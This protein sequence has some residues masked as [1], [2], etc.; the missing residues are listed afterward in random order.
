MRA[1]STR[2]SPVLPAARQRHAADA[3]DDR[4][5]IGEAVERVA[6]QDGVF[7]DPRIRVAPVGLEPRRRGGQ[8]LDE[9]GQAVGA[10]HRGA[11]VGE[12]AQV[13]AAAQR[14]GRAS[15]DRAPLRRRIVRHGVA[16]D[17]KRIKGRQQR[18]VLEIVPAGPVI[19]DWPDEVLPYP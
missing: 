10:Q 8:R 7:V 1:S 19:R 3:V 17:A 4:H 5:R 14:L 13:L 12:E 15:R 18:R 2:T 16:E 9:R 6:P 11:E